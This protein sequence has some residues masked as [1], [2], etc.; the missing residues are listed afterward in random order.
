MR[1]VVIDNGSISLEE[2]PTPEPGPGQ[3]RVR[4]HACG[5]N[6]ADLMQIRGTYPAPADAPPNIPGLE[7]AGVVDA[8]GPGVTDAKVGDRVFAIVGGGAYAEH[9]VVPARALAPIPPSLDFEKAAAIPEAFLTAYDAIVLQGGLAS[10][11]T[12]LIHAVGSGVGT[13]AV[14]IAQAIGAFS[15]GTAR[16]RDKLDKATAIGLGHGVLVE[17]D[18][19]FADKVR[20]HAPNGV[21]VVL[22]L[23]GGAYVPESLQTVAERG[24]VLLVGLLAGAAAEVP[25]GLMLRRRIQ[26]IGTVMRARPLEEKITLNQV[27][28]RHIAPLVAQKRLVPIIDRV[29][30]LENVQE[31]IDAM[32]S[33][34][35]FGKVVL[36]L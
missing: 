27:L 18:G 33:N 3:A 21:N 35:T 34:A 11:D 36:T 16:T 15:I 12:V 23:V 30:P 14:Q 8:I 6:R 22:E 4:I 10:G 28:K 31:A 19:K 29:L 7:I 5:V 13:A 1:A 25:L 32:A 17:K 9:V 20:A 2:V 26:L 24:R